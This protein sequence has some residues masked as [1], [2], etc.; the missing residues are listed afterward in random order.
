MPKNYFR[1][2][3]KWQR[4]IT[5]IWSLIF[6]LGVK[7]LYLVDGE[8]GFKVGGLFLAG[9]TIVTDLHSSLRNRERGR[10]IQ[11]QIQRER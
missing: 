3:L 10:M 8:D 4:H 5:S 6:L 7:M 11:E 9:E 2:I 1:N